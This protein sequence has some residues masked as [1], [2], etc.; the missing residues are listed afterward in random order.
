MAGARPLDAVDDSRQPSF[1][2]AHVAGIYTPRRKRHLTGL[3]LS[4]PALVF[5]G[6]FMAYP[7]ASLFFLSVHQYSPLRSTATTFVGF[8]NF[9][10]LV[11][12]DIVRQ[13]LWVTL[14]F[15]VTSV[16]LEMVIGLT[17]ATLLARLVLDRRARFG[18][19]LGR[20]FAA[21]FILP[22]AAP[23]IVAA[24]AWKLLLHPQFGPVD[25]LLGSDIGWFTQ[26]P[27]ASVVVTDAWKMMPF[28]LFLLFAA[29][30]SIEPDQFEAAT[31]DGA[32]SWQEFRYI[33]VPSILPV[34]AVTAAFRAVDAFTKI[35]D[36][37]FVTTGGGPGYDT[38]VLPLLIWKTA[39]EQLTFGRA[40][41]LSV[42]AVG[43]SALLGAGLLAIRRRSPA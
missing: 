35:F 34:L 23:A 5:T 41:A 12:S 42:V 36:T 18:R 30:L 14:L 15:T 37:V 33:T 19:L 32:S 26:F 24:M 13:S 40:A 1:G 29:I 4:L 3:G 39:F 43:I 25:A 38:Q 28:V 9:A 17:L 20:G 11:G 16:A 27:L 22:F 31:L 2:G 8:D 6:A 10:W 21:V 7:L